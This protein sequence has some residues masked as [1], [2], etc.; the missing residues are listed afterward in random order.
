M[1]TDRTKPSAATETPSASVLYEQV[2]DAVRNLVTAVRGGAS[3]RDEDA[4]W[5]RLYQRQKAVREA[6]Q[7]E[8][9]E[10]RRKLRGAAIVSG[11]AAMLLE[12][13]NE[14]E[15]QVIKQAQQITALQAEV[16]RLTASHAELIKAE[17]W[18]RANEQMAL[19]K[20]SDHLSDGAAATWDE[21]FHAAETLRDRLE[22]AEQQLAALRALEQDLVWVVKFIAYARYELQ[23]GEQQMGDQFP[24]QSAADDATNRL[25][26]VIAALRAQ[27]PQ[28]PT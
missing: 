19:R 13:K 22:Q 1:S 4:L 15:Q 7:Q 16:D 3:E 21:V 8:I 20:L 11:T 27:P 24:R 18:Y 10:L 14:A 17:Q 9:A 25:E 2:D 23:P 12:Q 26:R 5:V 28:E 6:D